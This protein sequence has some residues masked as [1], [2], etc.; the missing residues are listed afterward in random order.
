MKN[1]ILSATTITGSNVQNLEGKNIGNIQDLMI[2][3]ATGDVVY[4]VLSFGGF[5]GIG[6][7]YF[8]IPIETL[9]FSSRDDTIVLDVSKETL[10]NAPGFDKDNWPMT[11]DGAF[12][13]SVYSHYG[14]EMPRH[15]SHR[16]TI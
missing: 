8:A 7:K 14:T 10:E 6:D 9:D 12:I 4:A 11:A 15:R 5:L 3:P 1:T 2:D 13:E 16:S